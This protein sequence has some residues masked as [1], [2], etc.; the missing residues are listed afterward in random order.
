MD[1]ITSNKIQKIIKKDTLFKSC[2]HKD[3]NCKGK[4]IKAHSIQNNRVLNAISDNGHIISIKHQ[5]F[6]SEYPLDYDEIGRKIAS[7][8]PG[9]CSNHD[10]KIFKPIEQHDY[11]YENLEQEFIYAYRALAREYC[12]KYQAKKMT[13][14]MI[15]FKSKNNKLFNSLE[16]KDKYFINNSLKNIVK[17]FLIGTNNS[18]KLL[19]N[20]RIRF[21]INLDNRKFFK[22]RTR[23]IVL[24]KEYPIAVSSAFYVQKDL[25]TLYYQ[26]NQ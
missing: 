19:E 5:S 26:E 24:S 22:I 20:F 13:E 18:F 9:F 25:N 7:T 21:N 6:G 3:E 16:K 1:K 23:R 15:N 4:I 11:E 2:F 17:P 10:D 8:F 14:N 12:I